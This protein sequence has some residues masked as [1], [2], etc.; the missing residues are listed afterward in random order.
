MRSTATL[1]S[2]FIAAI[3]LTGCGESVSESHQN[4]KRDETISTIDQRLNELDARVLV[5]E[6]AREENIK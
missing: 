4:E 5:L 2:V 3:L 6:K 1:A